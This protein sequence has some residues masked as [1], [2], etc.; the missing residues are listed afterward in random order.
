[1]LVLSPVHWA[2]HCSLPTLKEI[3]ESSE[4]LQGS[5]F[6]LQIRPGE[7]AIC[8]SILGLLSAFHLV[9]EVN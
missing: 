3:S 4:P 2:L 9:F 1:M 5:N 7:E 6:L 8:C